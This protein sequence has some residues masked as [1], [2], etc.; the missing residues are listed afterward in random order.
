MLTINLNPGEKYSVNSK[1]IQVIPGKKYKIET[2]YLSQ[3]NEKFCAYFGVVILDDNGREI[4]RKVRWLG[5]DSGKLQKVSIIFTSKTN[6]ILLIYR[7][8]HE[9]NI[10]WSNFY[11][12][13]SPIDEIKLTEVD[14]NQKEDFDD[15]TKFKLPRPKELSIEQEDELEKNIVWIFGSPR[16]GTTWLGIQLLSYNTISINELYLNEH[17]GAGFLGPNEE[18]IRSFDFR[19]NSLNY[20][21]SETYD[22]TWKFYLRK[23]ILY[24]IYSQIKNFSQ[25][26]IIKEPH[27]KSG[28]D[29]ISKCLPNSKIIILLRDG[30]DV[31]DSLIDARKEGGFMTKH[32]F[33]VTEN[34]KLEFIKNRSEIWKK[35]IKILLTTYNNHPTE[36]GFLVKYENL[37]ENTYD[38]IKKIYD[39][40]GIE[41]TIDKLEQIVDKYQ[42]E[43]IPKEM[44]GKGKFARSATPGKWKDNFNENE[45]RI[46]NE[47]MGDTLKEIGY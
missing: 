3:K 19:K 33:V 4:N 22:A 1:K 32:S 38:I 30:R 9:T 36:N 27:N 29:I 15:H 39:F 31:I 25:K 26:I 37:R 12:Q 24:R 28:A 47:I 34:N 42:F 8:N 16:S 11:F 41:I 23:L 45:I 10:M 13:L 18:P 14:P 35:L 20:F 21:F 7:I 5:D 46:M 6:T 2:D 43:K 44:R 17:L 40:I